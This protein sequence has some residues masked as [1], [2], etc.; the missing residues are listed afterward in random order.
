MRAAHRL[1]LGGSMVLRR[2]VFATALALVA[3]ACAKATP[4]GTTSSTSSGGNVGGAGGGTTVST[5]TTSSG[6]TTG[7]GGA[8]AVCGNGMVEAGEGCDDGNT[9]VGDGCGAGCQPETGWSCAG[10]PSVCT[11]G[12]G[13][14]FI[15]GS[16]DC[17]DGNNL[18]NDGCDANCKVEHGWS[19]KGVPSK[20]SSDCGDGIV[21]A[22]EE[23]DDQNNKAGDGCA[24]DCK[25]EAGWVCQGEPSTCA[26]PCG[27]GII[28]GAEECDDGNKLSADGCSSTC[29]KEP[30]YTCSGTPTVCTSDCGDGIVA[31]DEECDDDNL[32]GGD[33]CDATCHKEMGW[34]CAGSPSTCT[35]IC[36]DGKVLG[37]ETCDDGN[38]VPG[39]GCSAT[40]TTQFGYTCTGAPSV[41][42]IV[43]GD[44]V[45]AGNEI[46]D[47]GNTTD[48]DGCSSGCKV[49]AGYVCAGLPSKCD[50][51]C[52]DGVING[53]E[54]CD[55][56]NLIP[57]DGCS[58]G[59]KV[60][61]GFQCTGSPSVCATVC[62]DG[63]QGGTEQCD[64]GNNKDGDGCSSTCTVETGF[65]C[66][67]T[68]PTV[69]API[70]GDK[71][72]VGTEKCDDGNT[73]NGDCCS[74]ACQP[75]PGCEIE[76]NDTLATANDFAALASNKKIKAFIT[77]ASDVDYF[78]VVVPSGGQSASITAQ[79]LDGAIS[80]DTCASN[81]LDTIL[82]VYDANNVQ[83][84][85]NNDFGG[86]FCSKVVVSGLS[87]GTYYVAV[88]N[89]STT[90]TYSYTLQVDVTLSICGNG[91][92]DFGEQCDDG[93]L[94]DGDG[95]SSACKLE[96]VL[97]EV[98]PNNTTANADARAAD[99]TPV[100]LTGTTVAAGSIGVAGDKDFFKITLPQARVVRF[101]TFDGINPFDCTTGIATKLTVW[102]STGTSL[103]TDSTTGIASC[104]ALVVY[105][106]AGTYYVSVEASSTTAILPL[107]F[108]EMNVHQDGGSE[109]EPNS[110]QAQADVFPGTNSYMFGGHQ[111]NTDVDYFVVSVSQGQSLRAEIVE[112]STAETCESNGIDSLL[113]VYKADGTQIASDDD[114]GRGFCSLLDGTG[115]TPAVA[116]LSKLPAGAYYIAV[117][118]STFATSG[119]GG[120][121]DY[122]LA[123]TLR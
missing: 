104:S 12:C 102:S 1:V 31:S 113:K 8:P 26:T 49:E 111:T 84:A 121:F 105:L 53:A 7:T 91:T 98:E 109:N 18:I 65:S 123:V 114:A 54:A 23:C 90:T 93:N 42:T 38:T 51:V 43:C 69:C 15:A 3:T 68:T 88:K 6:D 39:D 120:Q 89:F 10:S 103:W 20:C 92:K 22:G 48:G 63:A 9:A 83:L 14:G 116:A 119:A 62:G 32:V 16:E 64:D 35:A 95:C 79:T 67:G 61:V 86:N 76:A 2:V 25:L 108:L 40:C 78:K 118:A 27:D 37:A 59:C 60:E 87:P 56:G 70:C 96:G 100:L 74:S 97:Q 81:K 112:G 55:D 72:V 115:T 4:E 122:R 11:A 34:S 99:P 66:S 24:P 73:V 50:P 29:K 46:C 85:T 36:G 106:N 30:G 107:Y 82:T 13:D 58:P 45:I 41:C 19:C 47:D 75:E 80:G 77:P 44:G 57:G 71:I 110:T 33:G 28:A 101:E 5:S 21:A 52:G 117:Q 94:T 17:D